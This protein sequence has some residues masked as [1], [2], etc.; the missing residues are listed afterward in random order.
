M[1]YLGSTARLK[2][3]WWDV[4]EKKL[5]PDN[6]VWKV[7]DPAGALKETKTDPYPEDEEGVYD[8]D[9][10]LPATGKV[11]KWKLIADAVAGDRHGIVVL[12]FDVEE[13]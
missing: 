13:P 3:T 2:V 7:Y 8:W 9:Y 6:Q 5:V 4:D 11:G 12:E 10:T 1:V